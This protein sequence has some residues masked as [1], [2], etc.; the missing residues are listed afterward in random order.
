M[1]KQSEIILGIDFGTSY[2]SAAALI[3]GTI[4][5]VVDRGDSMIPSIVHYPRRGPPEVGLT[6][7]ARLPTAPHATVQSIKRILGR[8]LEDREVRLLDAGVGY[9]IDAG[10]KGLAVLRIGQQPY[11]CEQVVG[12]ILSYL[13]ELA[14]RRFGRRIS[15]AVIAVPAEAK[16]SFVSALRRA[17]KVAHLELLQ[18]IPEPIAGALSLGMHGV[19]CN[20]RIAVC[21]FGGGTFDATL[22][23]QQGLQFT[24]LA[25]HGNSTLGGDD[26]DLI[27]ANEVA[28]AIH[29]RCGYTIQND[30]VKWQQL[31]MRCESVKRILSREHEAR[32]AMSDA[33]VDKGAMQNID[34][35]LD[36]K[37]VERRWKPL[38][39]KMHGVLARLLD[40]A[41]CQ[42]QDIDEVVLIGG[43]SLIPMVQK[44]ITEFFRRDSVAMNDYANIAVAYG[45][46][47]QT[48]GH[49]AVATQL[50][51]LKMSRTPYAS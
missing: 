14:E 6:A 47:L 7:R 51:S 37:W 41:N 2:S 26:F 22:I 50:P 36:R 43:T 29:R 11:A 8:R 20:R 16:P 17:A 18:V 33:Y 35:L 46:A 30:V 44:G 24:P 10:P 21:D 31:R 27:M 4:Q 13:R 28:S 25:C 48:A 1:T 15:K 9:R 45:A 38:I 23:E 32:L 34:L 19:S 12:A 49:L 40:S 5:W 42:A 3:D 39:T